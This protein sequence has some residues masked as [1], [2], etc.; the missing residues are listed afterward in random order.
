MTRRS[1]RV[2]LALAASV[3]ATSGCVSFQGRAIPR[4]PTNLPLMTPRWTDFAVEGAHTDAATAVVVAS[5]TCGATV[6]PA[7]RLVL[8]ITDTV[9]FSGALDFF[10]GMT[11]TT[12]PAFRWHDLRVRGDL[13]EGGQVVA[14]AEDM[15]TTS[16]MLGWPMIFMLPYW[17]DEDGTRLAAANVRALT[18]AVISELVARDADLP[19]SPAPPEGEPPEGEVVDDTPVAPP[20][21]DTTS[22]PR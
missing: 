22:P 20:A 14:S 13:L 21:T 19:R 16:V 11:L 5:G 9:D 3:V 15:S 8:T 18:R 17:T 6:R 1:S 12:L 2:L 10:A 7:R 4:P